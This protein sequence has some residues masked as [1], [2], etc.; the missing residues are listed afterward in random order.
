MAEYL[1]TWMIDVESDTAEDAAREALRIQR[2]PDS[3]ATVFTVTD[4]TTGAATDVDLTE[5][6]DDLRI[7]RK[8]NDDGDF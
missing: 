2:K 1:V 7:I 3:I 4:K 5:L 8:F 6:D